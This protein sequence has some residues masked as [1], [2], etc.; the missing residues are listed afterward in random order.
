VG[1]AVRVGEGVWLGVPLPVGPPLADPV[2]VALGPGLPLPDAV[3]VAVAAGVPAP[4]GGT[5]L[6]ALGVRVPVPAGYNSLLFAKRK[7]SIAD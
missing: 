3:A 5:L 6:D 7:W 2:L 1:E 4:E